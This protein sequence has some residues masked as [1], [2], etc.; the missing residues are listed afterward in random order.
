LSQV[1]EKVLRWNSTF[2]V[3]ALYLFTTLS[4]LN[5]TTKAEVLLLQAAVI[6]SPY[7]TRSYLKYVLCWTI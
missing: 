7:Y 2:A 6:G 1:R 4:M 3:E 5:Y